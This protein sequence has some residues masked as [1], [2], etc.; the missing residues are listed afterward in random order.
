MFNDEKDAQNVV[1]GCFTMKKMLK[2]HNWMIYQKKDAQ[3]VITR[4]KLFIEV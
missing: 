1:T 4:V 3:I 2:C